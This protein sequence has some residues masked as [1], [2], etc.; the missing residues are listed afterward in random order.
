MQAAGNDS[1]KVSGHG[2]RRPSISPGHPDASSRPGT[3]VHDLYIPHP[4]RFYSQDFPIF[5]NSSAEER[6]DPSRRRAN[7]VVES[8]AIRCLVPISDESPRPLYTAS[9]SI[10]GRRSS[11]FPKPRTPRGADPLPSTRAARSAV[12]SRSGTKVHDLYI[13]QPLEIIQTICPLSKVHHTA[14]SSVMMDHTFRWRRA[15]SGTPSLPARYWC[16]SSAISRPCHRL[17]GTAQQS[18]LRPGGRGGE[19]W[20]RSG[21]SRGGWPLRSRAHASQASAKEQ[22]ERQFL[23]SSL[24]ESILSLSLRLIMG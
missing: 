6:A 10:S 13:P 14:R 2:L 4:W 15:G 18:S 3:K 12:S 16:L 22:Q 11:N 19:A 1:Q 23:L 21:R 5:R 20:R 17:T 7:S 9:P 24:S 8:A